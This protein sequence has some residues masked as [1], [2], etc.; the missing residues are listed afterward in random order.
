MKSGLLWYDASP[1]KPLAAKL[2]EAAQRYYQKFGVRPN[3]A[4]INPTAWTKELAQATSEL[5]VDPRPSILLN[6]IW[7]GITP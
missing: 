3:Q 6:H 4:Y 2:A 1:D 7:L 5:K